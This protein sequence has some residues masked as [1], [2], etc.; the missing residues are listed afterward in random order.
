MPKERDMGTFDHFQCKRP[1][2]ST[3]APSLLR[4]SRPFA[5]LPLPTSEQTQSATQTQLDHTA[6]FGH[7][8]DRISIFPPEKKDNT[9]LPDTLKAGIEGI[10][11]ISMDDVQ[12]HYH[13]SKP[14]QVQ[15]LAYT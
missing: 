11:G 6:R 2:T 9:G 8:F 1:L 5:P 10:S 4:P 15:A 7:A 12:V 13:S 3:P 14:A